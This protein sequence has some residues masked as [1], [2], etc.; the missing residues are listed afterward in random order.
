M[1]RITNE[2]LGPKAGLKVR[3]QYIKYYNLSHDIYNC[4]YCKPLMKTIK[5]DASGIWTCKKCNIK[6]AGYA[7]HPYLDL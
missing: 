4:I 7:Y 1:R 3:K 2:N 5:R 6:F